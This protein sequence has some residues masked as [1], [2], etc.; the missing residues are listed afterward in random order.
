MSETNILA[1]V[2]DTEDSEI[3]RVDMK[4]RVKLHA[5]KHIT[6]KILQSITS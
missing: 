5:Q 3:T 1:Q 4:Q 2:A 6:K